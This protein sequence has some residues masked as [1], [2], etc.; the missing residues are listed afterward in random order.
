V[1]AEKLFFPVA[2]VAVQSNG[3]IVAV[4]THNN[5]FI[6]ARLNPNGKLDPTFGGKDGLRGGIT[7]T[8]FG[9][10]RGDKALAVAIQKD[11]KIVVAGHM[12]DTSFTTLADVGGFIVARYNTDGSLDKTFDGDGKLHID[13][14][15]ADASFA[16]AVA[17]QPDGKILL[18]GTAGTRGRFAPPGDQN[19]FTV[20]RLNTNG[21]L[22]RT[23]GNRLAIGNTR[24]GQ[25]TIGFGGD[26]NEGASAIALAPDG[27]ILVGGVGGSGSAKFAV[28]RLH[29]NGTLDKTFGD[30]ISGD[31]RFNNLLLKTP[32]LRDLSVQPDGGVVFVGG[33]E[34]NF[35]VG[36]LTPAGRLDQSFAGR[37]H[38]TVDL[39]GNDDAKNVL[40]NR[41]GILVAGGSGGKFAMA[42]FRANG[43][44]DAAFGQGGKVVTA[45]ANGDAILTT[46]AT[47]DGKLLA[48]GRSGGVAR[49]F[50]AVPEVNVFSLDPD[51]AEGGNHASFIVTRS[52]RLSFPTRVFFGVGG[53][54]TS[55]ADYTGLPVQK[56]VIINGRVALPAAP[57]G[58]PGL[59]GFVDIPANETFALLPIT[60]TN[61]ALREATESIDLTL[62][63]SAAYALGDRA[64][65]MVEIRD[66]D[67]PQMIRINFQG[68][69]VAQPTGHHSDIGH[70]F[71]AKGALT[72][73]WDADNRANAR[74]QANAT[75]PD[76]RYDSYN[77]MQ[78]SGADRKWEIALPNGFYTVRLV[79][80]D[81]SH[82]NSV[83][84][85]NLEG[86][87]ALSG[88][89]TGDTRWFRQTTTVQV[90]DGR[91]TLT[92][93]AGAVNN[94][95]ALLEIQPAGA[96]PRTGA[97]S[98]VSVKAKT[99]EN[100]NLWFKT[101]NGFF[102]DKQIDEAMWE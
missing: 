99:P 83:Y 24:T 74:I 45:M 71:G 85:M 42:R 57:V 40:V 27:K 64:S 15:G 96:R 86:Q 91:L 67:L 56:P 100:V 13:T 69:G 3:K 53:T 73:G 94:K 7:L 41:E 20:A 55:G 81:A 70:V 6:V 17:I 82:T 21:S 54:A 28:A 44:L 10:D 80:G 68:L 102:S 97:V 78:K 35:V 8:N 11:G 14:A 95:I 5:D 92:N 32:A 4:G 2:D 37:G 30:G 22:D 76:F 38:T 16:S 88:T 31:G 12:D 39:G 90:R 23:F 61:D 93:A 66:N 51:G 36:K 19:D 1:L 65:Q 87:P 89:P 72:Y 34:G 79:A 59:S 29:T 25:L 33:S 75:S 98:A 101:S 50:A 26:S 46:T 49:Y 58:A 43:Q 60:V 77:H 84:R 18:A 63:A 52:Q 62:R 48:F 9:G 47:S